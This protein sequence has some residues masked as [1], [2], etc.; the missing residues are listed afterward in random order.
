ML[1][2]IDLYISLV[3][4]V[5]PNVFILTVRGFTKGL[6]LFSPCLPVSS[7]HV[8]LDLLVLVLS[9]VSSW[10]CSAAAYSTAGFLQLLR[11]GIPSTTL[12][13][14]L[15]NSP[16]DSSSAFNRLAMCR[17]FYQA[18]QQS[19]VGP[20]LETISLLPRLLTWFIEP[21]LELYSSIS[22]SSS[23][24]P[25]RGSNCQTEDVSIPTDTTGN[26]MRSCRRHTGCEGDTDRL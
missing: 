18:T 26:C 6:R 15:P 9:R 13:S 11:R 24:E 3:N 7:L 1:S 12:L 2:R 25:R 23:A 17:H 20:I 10:L 19:I 14:H 22:M 4:R 8:L 16:T 21:L 5:K